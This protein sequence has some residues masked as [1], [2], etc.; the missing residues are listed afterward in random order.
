MKKVMIILFSIVFL[1]SCF[2]ENDFEK[3]NKKVVTPITFERVDHY[4]KNYPLRF[5]KDN[6]LEEGRMGFYK[7]YI[8]LHQLQPIY[9]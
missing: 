1:T 2:K 5:V 4:I 7:S 8:I 9:L 6:N 3:I